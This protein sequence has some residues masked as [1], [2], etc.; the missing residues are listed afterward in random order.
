MDTPQSAAPSR[1][2]PKARRTSRVRAAAYFLLLVLTLV[3]VLD[4]VVGERG[5]VTLIGA[6][7][8][9]RDLASSLDSLRA[10]NA[11]LREEA[12]TL[13]EDPSAIEE[14]AR[15]HLGLILPGETLFIVKDRRT[16]NV[17]PREAPEPPP[18]RR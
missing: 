2:P 7:R 10:E 13:R 11:A 5:L 18:A 3:L 9:Y 16:P 15:R 8:E 14:L 4:A 6:T 1:R 17:P 12:R